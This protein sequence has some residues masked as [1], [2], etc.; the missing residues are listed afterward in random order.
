MVAI[1]YSGWDDKKCEPIWCIR[2]HRW[3]WLLEAASSFILGRTMV[4]LQQEILK[5]F[6]DFLE[7]SVLIPTYDPSVRHTHSAAG[8]FSSLRAPQRLH[9]LCC[10]KR[11][12]ERNWNFLS[13]ARPLCL[14]CHSRTISLPPTANTITMATP[15][16]AAS[17]QYLVEQ[18][19][20]NHDGKIII[21]H[22]TTYPSDT[23]SFH[24]ENQRANNPPSLPLSPST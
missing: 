12:V 8:S 11:E 1:D 14:V 21:L 18:A 19:L 9:S 6:L 20:P 17:I 5:S 22:P 23:P 24:Q 16:L 2:Q 7:E 10:Q 13:I 3:P 4:D 15:P